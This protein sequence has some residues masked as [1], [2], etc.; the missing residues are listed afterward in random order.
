[1][2]DGDDIARSDTIAE[3]HQSAVQC[4][5]VCAQMIFR[6]PN[7][8]VGRPRAVAVLLIAVMFCVPPLVRATARLKSNAVTQFRLNRGFH[9][10]ESK[11]KVAPPLSR[12]AQLPS[13]MEPPLLQV[14]GSVPPI[15]EVVL[16]FQHDRSPDPQRGPPPLLNS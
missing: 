14:V 5:R 1:L 9:L 4:S 15:D 11:L 12:P 3:K 6:L 8:G 2:G 7:G 10:P 13:T 16:C